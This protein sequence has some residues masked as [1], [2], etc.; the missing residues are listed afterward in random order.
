MKTTKILFIILVAA[1]IVTGAACKKFLD[2]QPISTASPAT[3]WKDRS[4]ANTWMAGVYNSLQSALSSNYIDWGEVRSDNLRV[5]GTGNAQLTMITNTLSAND[6]DINGITRWT[7]IYTTISLCN[8]G[9]KYMPQMIQQDVGGGAASFREY[10]AQCYALRALSYFY[11]L[12]VWG[13]VPLHVVPIESLTQPTELP[14]SPIADIKKRIL[15]DITEALKTAKTTTDLAPATGQKYYMTLGAIYALKTDVHM[16]FQ[17]YDDALTAS[18][19]FINTVGA[20]NWVTNI[21]QWKSIFTDPANSTETVFNLYWSA[22]ERGGGVGVCSRIGSSSNTNNYEATTDLWLKIKNRVDPVTGKTTDGRY[23]AYWDTVSYNTQQLYDDAVA[24][25]GKYYPWRTAPG[26][27]F[28]FQGNSDCDA[29]IPIYRYADIMLLR[30]EALNKKGQHQPALDI[31]N[32]V[33]SRVGYL[34]QAKLS[35]YTGDITAGIEQTILEE[36]QIELLGE[37]KRWFDM[38]RIGLIYNYTDAGYGYLRQI[39]NPILASRTGGILY[40]G[41]NMGRILFPI[42]SDAFNANPKLVGDQNPPYDE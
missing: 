8:Y 6:A 13:R 12:R 28:I 1:T 11:A 31:V 25:I 10:L 33:R 2:K 29:K 14:R 20:N 41:E 5:G 34:V 35:D 38:S 37:G 15:D 22:T 39:M 24:Q 30:A 19:S 9:I 40:Q 36:R 16:W 42:N 21:A 7:S 26:A 3:F 32:K 23:W 17:E 27:G 18:Q 4:D